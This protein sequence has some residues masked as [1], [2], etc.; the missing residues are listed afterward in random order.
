MEVD[1]FA[2]VMAWWPDWLLAITAFVTAATGI[3]M[4]TPTKADNVFLD[5]LLKFLNVLAGNTFKNKNAD[6]V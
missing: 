6:D 1:W 3:T 2:Q 4:L 5:K